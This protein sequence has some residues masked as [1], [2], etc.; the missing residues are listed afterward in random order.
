MTLT[1][2]RNLSDEARA[3]H[4]GRVFGMVPPDDEALDKG[5]RQRGA[6]A[7]F[8]YRDA[9]EQVVGAREGVDEPSYRQRPE[10]A[11]LC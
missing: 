1:D 4:L 7:W 6:F 5:A 9:L 10:A 11:L 2:V 3:K 8:R